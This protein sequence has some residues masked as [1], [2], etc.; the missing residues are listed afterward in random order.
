[1]PGT[2]EKIDRPGRYRPSLKA[3]GEYLRF[4]AAAVQTTI[5]EGRQAS[6]DGD[7]KKAAEL[8]DS[9][10]MLLKQLRMRFG[11]SIITSPAQPVTPERLTVQGCLEPLPLEPTEVTPPK[12]LAAQLTFRLGQ[13]WRKPDGTNAF[14]VCDDRRA[15]SIELLWSVEGRFAQRA[16][17]ESRDLA[18]YVAKNNLRPVFP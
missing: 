13:V 9:L 7:L 6:V 8:W 12:T 3:D 10:D 2:T 15:D 11:F 14:M 18:A 4:F 17:M 5:H 16:R 1:M